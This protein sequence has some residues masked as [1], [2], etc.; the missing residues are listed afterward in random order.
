MHPTATT[1]RDVTL[2]HRTN[3]G[4]A[5]VVRLVK[6]GRS[7]WHGCVLWQKDPE[8]GGA[9]TEGY[10]TRWEKTAYLLIEG[11]QWDLVQQIRRGHVEYEEAIRQQAAERDDAKR[12]MV[13]A[14]E[15]QWSDDHPTPRRES[16]EEIVARWQRRNAT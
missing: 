12:E 5:S 11:Q 16:I 7:Y 14:W 9:I 13:R 6:N 4:S 10:V 15:D 2:I 1:P 8:E 3:S